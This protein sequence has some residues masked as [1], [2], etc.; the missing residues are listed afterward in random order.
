MF[1]RQI[2]NI[3]RRI[4]NGPKTKQ[5][6]MAACFKNN[7]NNV[8]TAVFCCKVELLVRQKQIV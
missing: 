2:L 4:V 3:G 5:A 7:V 1:G 8:F 6:A